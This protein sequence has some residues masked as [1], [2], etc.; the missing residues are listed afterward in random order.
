MDPNQSRRTRRRNTRAVGGNGSTAL[1]R[2]TG[3]PVASSAVSSDVVSRLERDVAGLV[4]VVGSLVASLPS[5]SSSN[6][7]RRSDS[8]DVDVVRSIQRRFETSSHRIPTTGPFGG[9]GFAGDVSRSDVVVTLIEHVKA[10]DDYREVR[11]GSQDDFDAQIKGKD[12]ILKAVRLVFSNDS[13]TDAGG[14]IRILV[15]PNVASKPKDQAALMLQPAHLTFE[16]GKLPSEWIVPIPESMTVKY[17]AT[18]DQS[19]GAVLGT[20]IFR[21]RNG[22]KDTDTMVMIGFQFLCAVA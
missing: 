10:T 17:A 3:S 20:T 1:V 13:T 22:L 16:L 2:Y 7:S 21:T 11:T 14:H 6:R 8:G 4:K 15:V 5:G 19:P 12:V 18:A 9:S